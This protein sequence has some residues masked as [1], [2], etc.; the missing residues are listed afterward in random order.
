L[1][2]SC[3]S[4]FHDTIPIH[5]VRDSKKHKILEWEEEIRRGRRRRWKRTIQFLNTG[6]PVLGYKRRCHVRTLYHTMRKFKIL[7]EKPR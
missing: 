7:T 5:E 3:N 2:G 4:L 6:T 1:K